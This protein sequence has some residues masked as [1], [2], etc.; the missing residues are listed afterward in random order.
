MRWSYKHGEV[1]GREDMKM[2][3]FGLLFPIFRDFVFS[4]FCSCLR[5]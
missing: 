5:K 2:E 1:E 3:M 4:S